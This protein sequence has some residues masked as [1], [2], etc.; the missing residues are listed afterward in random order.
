MKRLK[1]ILFLFLTTQ[2]NSFSQKRDDKVYIKVD[3]NPEFVYNGCD[4]TEDC[5]DLFVDTYKKWPPF[6][7]SI[8]ATII[9]QCIVER[10]GKLTNFKLLRGVE[11]HIDKASIDV[12]KTM[13]L[14]KPGKI[15]GK[16]VRTQI[17][18]RVKWD[19]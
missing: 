14:W 5:I 11:A 15:K 7:G 6:E 10:N 17:T 4:K 16:K 1:I 19:G 2:F 13:P 18:I 8:K 9:I 12:L 3:S